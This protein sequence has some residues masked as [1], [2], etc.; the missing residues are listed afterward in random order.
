MDVCS[1]DY[2]VKVYPW[3]MYAYPH[4]TGEGSSLLSTEEEAHKW[5]LEQGSDS[6]W[7]DVPEGTEAPVNYKALYLELAHAVLV[8]G[9]GDHVEFYQKLKIARETFGNPWR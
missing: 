4:G 1:V 6:V 3:G 8:S 5:L 7:K 9:Y 2:H